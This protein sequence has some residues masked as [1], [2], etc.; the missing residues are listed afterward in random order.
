MIQV[1]EIFII[2]FK[3]DVTKLREN[4]NYLKLDSVTNVVAETQ[5]HVSLMFCLSNKV[6]K[7]S[8]KSV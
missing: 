4:Y 8:A 6:S 5:L 7:L 3:Q 2:T 1:M